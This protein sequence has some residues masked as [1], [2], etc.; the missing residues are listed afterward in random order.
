VTGGLRPHQDAYGRA[1]LDFHEG[2]RGWTPMIERDDGNVDADFGVHHYFEQKWDAPE[3]EALRLARGRVLDVGGG[4]G[5]VALHLQKKGH[6][7]VAI[8][9]SPLTVKVMKERGV[10]DARILPFSRVDGRLG[11]FD[12]LVMWGNNFGLFGRANGMR[13]MLRR[14]KRLTSENARII[15]QTVNIYDTDQPIHLA[16]HRFNRKRG[17]LP[18]ELRIR[19]RYQTYKTPWFDYIMVSPEEMA[20]LAD[21]TGWFLERVIHYNDRT[22]PIYFGVLEKEG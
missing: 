19:V 11:T 14:L 6:D 1:M 16:Y 20:S 15:A 9:N 10:K 4:A 5:R 8:D 3:R 13:W 17:R 18:G 22:P 21:G 12:T 7:V 2:R